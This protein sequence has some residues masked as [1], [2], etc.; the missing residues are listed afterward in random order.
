MKNVDLMIRSCVLN[1]LAVFAPYA[2][3]GFYHSDGMKKKI[4]RGF[5]SS[6]MVASQNQEE[7]SQD[8]PV[9]T[10]GQFRSTM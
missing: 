10:F 9:G 1:M 3:V 2:F 4:F 5:G 8:I 6:D 7:Q